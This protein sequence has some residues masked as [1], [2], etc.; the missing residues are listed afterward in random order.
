MC[1]LADGQRIEPGYVVER[2]LGAGAFAEV[3]RVRHPFLGRQAMKVFKQVG[4]RAVVTEMLAEAV[5]LSKIGHPNIVRV[6]DAGT[7]PT[8]TGERGFFTMEYVGGGTLHRR[9]S[10]PRNG[11]MPV[12]ETVRILHDVSQ[13]LA[14]A[15]AERIIH[16]DITP[17]NI[18]VAPDGRA[19]L[20]DF[21]LAKVARPRPGAPMGQL[22]LAYAAPESVLGSVAESRAMDVW[23]LGAVAYLL[24]TDRHPCPEGASRRALPVPPDQLNSEVDGRLAGIVQGALRPHP[25]ERT[26]NAVVLARQLAEWSR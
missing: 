23:S 5:L 10:E 4:S 25:V 24:L 16:R 7:V 15:H 11:P 3:Y 21:G 22:T 14:A 13:G 1:F 18:L 8:A 6:F 9:W 2:L 19:R 17:H 12:A 20:G 26:P